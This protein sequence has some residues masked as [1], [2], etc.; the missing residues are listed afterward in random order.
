MTDTLPATLDDLSYP[1]QFTLWSMRYWANGVRHDFSPYAVL[2]EAYWRAKCP[3]TLFPL[4]SFLSL[5]IAG[6]S[7]SVDIRCTCSKKL[8]SDE[9]RILHAI[10]LAQTGA[11]NQIS[12]LIG[13]FLAPATVRIACPAILDWAETL[14]DSG[15]F[16]PLRSGEFTR[17]IETKDRFSDDRTR[18]RL[19]LVT[20]SKNHTLH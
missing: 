19:R 18:A 9:W 11:H 4:D 6:Y 5:M 15:L 13:D 12:E 8:S 10:A 14:K 16:L 1:E 20:G 7:R 17:N 3:R 2:Q